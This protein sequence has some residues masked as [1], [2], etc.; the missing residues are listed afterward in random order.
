M[1]SQFE[2]LQGSGKGVFHSAWCTLEDL[3]PMLSKTTIQ[4]AIHSYAPVP[5]P[6]VASHAAGV[7]KPSSAA[8]GGETGW[9]EGVQA[10]ASS[11]VHLSIQ[12]GLE[13]AFTP[14]SYQRMMLVCTNNFT[15]SH[16]TFE[17]GR[18]PAERVHNTL[19]NPGLKFGP[20]PGEAVSLAMTVSTNCLNVSGAGV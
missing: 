17:P 18:R 7:C 10:A 1:S 19:F 16:T 8:V 4:A 20:A 12:S 5:S 13:V 6:S 9:A 14:S 3:V 11:V 2:C 15:E